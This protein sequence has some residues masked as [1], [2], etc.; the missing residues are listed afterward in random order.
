MADKLMRAQVTIPR[1]TGVPEDAFTN[2][3]YFDGDDLGG[4]IADGGYHDTVM[5]LLGNFYH[6]ID[7][8]LC[9]MAGTV[10]TVKIYDMRDPEPRIPERIDTIALTLGTG[11]WMPAEVAL[12]LS[13]QAAGASGVN[14][15]RRRGRVYLGPIDHDAT[16]TQ[17]LGDVRPTSTCRDAIAAAAG[18]LRDGADT[19]FG[20]HVSWA[21][22]S[23]TLDVV[24]TIDDAFN[25]VDNGW[26]DNSFDTQRRRGS[27]PSLRSLFS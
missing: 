12:C 8:F 10:A 5:T 23:P 16:Y 11:D 2:T 21:V 18:A 25:D 19:T 6:A 17:N 1:V 13:F 20:S 9:G 24:G 14:Q 22:Y 7:Q 15:A 27:A 4:P 26:V 3:W